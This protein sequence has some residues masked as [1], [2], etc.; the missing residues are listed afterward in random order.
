MKK[1]FKYLALPLLVLSLAACNNVETPSS[2]VP[3]QDNWLEAD[4]ATMS[5]TLGSGN[6]IPFSGLF[7][8]EGN[9]YAVVEYFS[10]NKVAVECLLPNIQFDEQGHVFYSPLTDVDAY[11]DLCV[12]KEFTLDTGLS[13]ADKHDYFLSKTITDNTNIKSEMWL[14]IYFTD[15]NYLVAD[16]WIKTDYLVSVWPSRVRLNATYPGI[17]SLVSVA[18]LLGRDENEILTPT[19]PS[20]NSVAYTSSIDEGNVYVELTINTTGSINL[21][22]FVADLFNSSY[23][24]DNTNGTENQNDY[25]NATSKID[26]FVDKVETVN[27]L[28]HIFKVKFIAY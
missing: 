4:L 7:I 5:S 21:A 26:C 14:N 6:E 22:T 2:E 23:D 17:D 8:Q 11:K 9:E 16:A 19:I 25:Y 27:G 24:I 15:T 3:L 12:E 18:E 1:L 10:V 13:N 28:D 20:Y